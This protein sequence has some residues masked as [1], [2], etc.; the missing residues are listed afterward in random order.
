MEKETDRQHKIPSER[1]DERSWPQTEKEAEFVCK[2]D[3]LFL[4]WTFRVAISAKII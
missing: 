4:S 3:I 2:Y 1:Q